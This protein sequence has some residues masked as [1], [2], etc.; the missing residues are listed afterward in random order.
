P[1]VNV[2]L[3]EPQA[4]T[5]L[6]VGDLLPPSR[7]GHL[8]DRAFGN[9]E[10]ICHA[11]DRPEFLAVHA[12]LLGAPRPAEK[13]VRAL[14]LACQAQVSRKKGLTGLFGPTNRPFPLVC[15]SNFLRR[16][17]KPHRE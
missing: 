2:R 4:P 6:D 8:V 10:V 7:C 12:A 3:P 1:A 16:S 14:L 11:L 15:M 9:A 13:S 5:E 17:R